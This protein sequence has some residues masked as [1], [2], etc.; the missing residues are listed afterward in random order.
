M[1]KWQSNQQKLSRKAEQHEKMK[2]L[3]EAKLSSITDLILKALTDNTISEEEYSLILA[4]L[5]KFR[6]MKENLRKT[7]KT[8]KI[9]QQAT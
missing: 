6:K 2:F 3:A 8:S 9:K 1:Y 4:E 7:C 5:D